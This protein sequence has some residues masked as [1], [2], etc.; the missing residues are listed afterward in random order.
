[1]TETE[2]KVPANPFNSLSLFSAVSKPGPKP[3]MKVI[4]QLFMFLTWLR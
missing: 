1:M 3:K 2:E 4:D